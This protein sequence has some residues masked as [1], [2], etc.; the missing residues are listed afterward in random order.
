MNRS[1]LIL[2]LLVGLALVLSIGKAILQNTLST[3]G[4]FVSQ[5]KQEIDYYKTQNAILS[6]ELLTASSLSIIAREAE[7]AGFVGASNQFVLKTSH[8]LSL[9]P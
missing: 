9:R 2:I 6:E 4:I 8:S 3:S 7:K 5:A 1:I